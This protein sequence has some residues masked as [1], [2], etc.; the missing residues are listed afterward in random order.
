MLSAQHTQSSHQLGK[1]RTVDY[2][3]KIATP[4]NSNSKETRS[5]AATYTTACVLSVIRLVN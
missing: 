2:D 4:F 5:G 3:V 1:A